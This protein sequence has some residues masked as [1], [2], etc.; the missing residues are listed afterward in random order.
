M[1]AW[2]VIAIFIF[3][4]GCTPP[5]GRPVPE[6]I[7]IPTPSTPT[8]SSLE[9]HVRAAFQVDDPFDRREAVLQAV[10]RFLSDSMVQDLTDPQA[11][12]L[13]TDIAFSSEQLI[14]ADAA[15]IERDG[16]RAVVGLPDGLGLYFY[17]LSDG[18]IAPLELSR[19]T[20][21]LATIEASWGQTE[22]GVI[23]D[24]LGNDGVRQA[25]YV[26]TVQDDHWEVGW[27]SDDSPD[28]WFN[29]R[30]A[31]LGLTPDRS[32][33]IVSGEALSTTYIFDESGNHPRRRF[34]MTWRRRENGYLPESPVSQY[35]T[36]EAWL[37][38]VAE[39]SPYA[40]LVEFIERMQLGDEHGASALVSRPNVLLDATSYGLHLLGR[41]YEVIE[42]EERR[43]V[44]RDAQGTFVASFRERVSGE[45]RWMIS[46]L[47]PLGAEP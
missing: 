33:I 7:A 28:W 1:A 5:E 18:S 8:P 22:V 46:E 40:V 23:Y 6:S 3:L 13:L 24:T 26:L 36:R 29:S 19:W 31:E 10:R 9:A 2:A 32:W 11:S 37:W 47:A 35:S 45:V 4:A 20:A 17:D 14:L 25:H 30:N 21:G 12:L 39:A 16:Q 15:L 38:S 42:H 43:I 41:Q 34:R 44:F 27:L